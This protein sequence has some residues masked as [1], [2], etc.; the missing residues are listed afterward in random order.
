MSHADLRNG[1]VPCRYL[2]NF[3]MNFKIS[4][5]CLLNL[6]NGGAICSHVDKLHVACQFQVIALSIL[7]NR[8]VDFKGR[9]PP[10]TQVLR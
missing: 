3:Y 9:G 4:W 8:P 6:R 5:C 7:R 10:G 1:N 2:G